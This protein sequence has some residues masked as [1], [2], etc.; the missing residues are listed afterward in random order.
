[1]DP[2][3][4]SGYGWLIVAGREYEI[5]T[6]SGWRFRLADDGGGTALEL[7]PFWVGRGGRLRSPGGARL[8]LRSSPLRRGRWRLAGAPGRFSITRDSGW[9]PFG[10]GDDPVVP[11]LHVE[12]PAETMVLVELR[13][14]LTFACWLIVLFESTP[15]AVGGGGG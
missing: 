9:R 2:P 6:Y 4:D 15:G 13:V 7:K 14:A 1:V 10:K 3:T 5:V 12:M 8:V 11:T